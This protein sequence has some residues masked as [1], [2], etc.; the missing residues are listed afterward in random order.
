VHSTQVYPLVKPFIPPEP[1]SVRVPYMPLKVGV[2]SMLEGIDFDE[3]CQSLN[4]HDKARALIRQIRNSPPTRGVRSFRGNVTGRF[5][6]RKM[7]FTI[8]FESHKNELPAIYEYE[9]DDEV[10]EY[11]DQPPQIKL[12]YEASHGKRIGVLHTPDFFLM[13]SSESGWEEC[14]TEEELMKLS[15]KNAKR[16]FR[17]AE[18]KWRCPPGEIHAE[19][20]GLYYRVRSSNDISWTYQRNLEFLDDYFRA[21]STILEAVRSSVRAEVGAQPGLTLKDLFHRVERS[22]SL[23]SIFLLVASGE[24]YVDLHAAPLAEPDRVHVFSDRETAIAFTSLIHPPKLHRADVPPSLNLI[25]GNA[26]Q[27][28]SK[29][30]KIVNVGE[31]KIGLL[32]EAGQFIEVPLVSFEKLVRESCI[33]SIKLNTAVDIHPEAK[34][35]L[36]QADQHA[37]AEANRRIEIV[38]AY[39]RGEPLPKEIKI[40]E[41]T[42]RFWAAQCRIAEEMYGTDYIGVLPRRK[43]GNTM[44][45]LPASTLSLMDEFVE[46]EYETLKQKRKYEVYAAFLRACEQRGILPTSYKT[47]IKAVK[48]RPRYQQV[49]KRQGRKAAYKH[50]EFYWE[51]ALTTPRHG[52]RPLHVAH[53]DHTELDAELLCST[54]RQNLGRAWLTLLMDAFSRRILAVYLTFDPPSYRSCMMVIRECVR[55]FGRLPQTV[56][57]DGGLE[58][59]GVYFETLLARYE[60]TKKVRP[61]AESRFGSVCERLFGTTNTRF[62]HNLQGNTQIMRNVRQVTKA[63]SPQ[64]QAIWSLEKLYLYFCEWAYEVYDTIDHPALGQSPRDAFAVGMLNTGERAHRLIAYNNDFQM[65]T[66][67]TTPKGTAKIQPGRGVKIRNIYY[68]SAAFRDPAIEETRVPVRYDPFDSSLAY[69]YVS[70]QW[71]EC[72][73]QHPL[74]FR[75]HSE[76]ELMIATA[77]LRRRQ[78][79]HSGQ[80]NVTALKLAQFLESVE[81][82]EV[83]LRQRATDRESQNI[84]HVINGGL[85]L[86]ANE[87]MDC[88][89]S[90]AI[91]TVNSPNTGSSLS[92]GSDNTVEL[93]LYEEL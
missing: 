58:F 37:Y 84:L 93:K 91:L 43:R 3:W 32:G 51:L 1:G 17:D 64:G 92:D 78:A 50:K 39:E 65:F 28:D 53:I 16:Y 88:L 30:W 35:L 68:W 18:G 27:W 20:V 81:S 70:G 59:S 11:Y 33:T 21:D 60:C 12:T 86:Q 72:L 26:I 71:T 90:K 69:A 15:A 41:R 76:R 63:I 45:K 54:T 25:V 47:F 23:D 56:V 7:G 79:R 57:V 40:P 62:I 14:K 74:T 10:L 4:L 61:P 13:R 75:G 5:P 46:N 29:G 85:K 52:E 24:L 44:P 2:S 83:L 80:F 67:P 49:S 55:R 6:S 8:Q 42:V 48:L 73:S 66:F 22:A 9:H 36:E 38:R 82:E 89:P 19:G 87:A 77:E 31:T 34:R